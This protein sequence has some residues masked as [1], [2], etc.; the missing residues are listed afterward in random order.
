MKKLIVCLTVVA[1]VLFATLIFVGC[2]DS[3][4]N[5]GP[6]DNSKTLVTAAENPTEDIS[7]MFYIENTKDSVVLYVE[8][9]NDW[10]M[11]GIHEASTDTPNLIYAN[12]VTHLIRRIITPTAHFNF[13]YNKSVTQYSV[14][15]KTATGETNI[16]N[17]IP[18]DYSKP[19][20]T[21][22]EIDILQSIMVNINNMNDSANAP[23]SSNKDISFAIIT[24]PGLALILSLAIVARYLITNATIIRITKGTE[25][26]QVVNVKRTPIENVGKLLEAVAGG[27][28]ECEPTDTTHL[29]ITYNEIG[30]GMCAA[31]PPLQGANTYPYT[32]TNGTPAGGTSTTQNAQK[33]QSCDTDYTLASERCTATTYPY[34]C[35]NGNPASG[36]SSKPNTQK[37]Q[38]C[39]TDY[40]LASERCTATTYPYI[41][42]NGTPA[43]GTTDTADT[44]KCSQCDST[45]K[46][47]GD[48]CTD[49]EYTCSNGVPT[50]GKPAG[51]SDTGKCQ[52][53]M[54][55]YKLVNNA[56]T[57]IAYTCE[58]GNPASGSP[59]FNSDTEK[60][61]SCS[62]GYTLASERCTVTTYPYACTNG[63]P[64]GG[65]STAQNT[66]K[67]QSCD[68]DYTLASER[69]T[70]TTYPYTCTNGTPAGGTSTAQN[71]QKCQS[72]DT[73]YTLASERCTKETATTH[74]YI[75]TNGIPAAGTTETANIENCTSCTDTNTH[76]LT[77]QSSGRK[78]CIQ[79][80]YH[81][82]CT[83]GTPA[84]GTSTAQNTQKCQS[85]DTG[86]TLASER[87][88][89]TTYPYTCTNGTKDD[90]TADTADT[91]K[92][93]E[94][95]TGFTLSSE[96]CTTATAC[97]YHRECNSGNYCTSLDGDSR[98][99][100]NGTCVQTLPGGS[101]CVQN[102]QCTSGNCNCTMPIM[103][104]DTF[105]CGTGTCR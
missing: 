82:T 21:G 102:K 93:A 17:N 4:T 9:Q 57:P 39:D 37:C 38:S 14:E 97:S 60:C 54:S 77:D 104:G 42:T 101:V 44:E 55:T 33:C 67:C 91:E 105:E 23:Q 69:C 47:V 2:G 59:A 31:P 96:R 18:F 34:T 51:N 27:I 61:T 73:G 74:N 53:C 81:Y 66:Q 24:V 68:T 50:V 78:V 10:R 48:T 22:S 25:L 15:H 62:A 98:G 63:T 45:Y 56:C 75:C 26:E 99:N 19:D 76:T 16:Y 1:T 92:C 32:C 41:C 11:V 90:G 29:T 46:L 3:T 70:A 84:G 71:T 88:T 20:E 8:R 58:N 52:S 87:C 49:T 36:V 13:T 43:T 65:T 100:S 80:A 79:T 72:C 7:A 86:Y 103:V 5:E 40:T 12:P 64:A 28:L 30:G 85:C 35:T 6:T 95:N 94:C 83:N 89:V